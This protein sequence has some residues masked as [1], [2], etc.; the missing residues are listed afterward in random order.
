MARHEKHTADYFPF[1][2]KEGKTLFV[3][4]SQWGAT[5]TGVFTNVLRFLCSTPDH[6]YSI[7]DPGDRLYFFSK[8]HIDEEVGLKILGAMAKTDKIDNFLFDHD[9]I[10]CQNLVDS[11]KD[12]YRKRENNQPLSKDEIYLIYGLTAEETT[13]TADCSA[14]N[15]EK[16]DGNEQK[17]VKE[18]KLNKKKEVISDD[19]WL[20]S[21]EDNPVYRG[22]EVRILYGKMLVWCENNGKEPTRRR[23]VNWL[24]RAEIPLQVNAKNQQR[25]MVT[26]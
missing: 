14:G 4:E 9:V 20:K 25:G 2:V 6:H 19:E 26:L 12:A 18:K 8:L 16:G 10:Y 17:K 22:I 11:L 15:E 1:V 5:G 21:L 24:N 13:N 23:F 7:K 3:L